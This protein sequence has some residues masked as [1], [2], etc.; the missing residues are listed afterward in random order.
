MF[1]LNF[2]HG[3]HEYHLNTLNTIRTAMKNLNT[4]VGIL[5]DISGPKVRVGELKENF[6]LKKGDVITFLAEEIIGYKKS[7]NEYVVSINYPNV[8]KKIKLDEYIYLYDGIIRAKVIS[9][10]GSIKAKIESNG[11]LSSRKGVNFPNTQIDINVI[12]KKDEKD[13]AWGIEN[14]VDYFAISFV[15]NAKDMKKAKKLLKGYDG[16]LSCKN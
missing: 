6:E 5:Q 8:L 9:I 13:I 4:N 2:S 14:K 10:K 1:R 15:Q 11:T 7:S 12:T 16:K 3:S